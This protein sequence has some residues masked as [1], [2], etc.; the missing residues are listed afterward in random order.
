MQRGVGNEFKNSVLYFKIFNSFYPQT[1]L[2]MAAMK[3]NVGS[4]KVLLE[5]GANIQTTTVNSERVCERVHRLKK[6]EVGNTDKAL[7]VFG[8]PHI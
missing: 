4:L 2:H 8:W 1:P 5:Y 3:G 7:W 6:R